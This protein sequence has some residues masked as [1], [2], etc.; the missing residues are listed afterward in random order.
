M[1]KKEKAIY[2]PGELDRLRGKL[3][4]TDAGEAKR[5]AEMLGG[6]VGVERQAAPAAP[7]RRRSGA[8]TAGQGS[9]RSNRTGARAS[10]NMQRSSPRGQPMRRVELAGDENEGPAKFAKTEVSPDPTGDLPVLVKV[11]WFERLKMDYLCAQLEFDIKSPAQ[12]IASIFSFFGKTPDQVNP[13]FITTLLNEYYKQVEVLVNATRSLFPRNNLKRSEGLKKRS[14]FFYSILDTIR[15]WDIEQIAAEIAKLQAH[16]QSVKVA[17]CSELLKLIYRPLF[18]LEQMDMETHIKGAFQLLYKILYIENPVEAKAKYQELIRSAFS[19]FADVRRELHY[20]LYP[21][22]MKLLSDSLLP[23][24]FFFLQQRSRFTAFIGAAEADQINPANRNVRP[25]EREDDE[26]AEEEENPDDRAKQAAR[27][28]EQKALDRGLATLEAL[29]PKAGWNRLSEY[30]DL[31][32]YFREVF[33]FK[34]GYELIAPTDP[35]QQIEILMRILEELFFALRY[36]TFSPITKQGDTSSG[37]DDFLRSIANDWRHY[38]DTCF[39]KEYLPRLTEYCRIL[40]NAAESRTSSYARRTLD[41][42]HWIKRLYFLPYYKFESAFPPPFQKR[43]VTA[44]YSEIRRLR[45]SLTAVAAGIE[46]GY[47][48]GG[49]EKMAPC[50]GIDNPWAPYNFEIPNPVSRRLNALLDPKKRNNA[51][52]IFFSLAVTAVL[53]HLVNDE[54]SWA[55]EDRPGPLFRSINGDGVI[56]QFGVDD[57][58]DVEQILRTP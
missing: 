21:L 29:F 7:P 30:P 5:L 39:E 24:E 47:K 17:E 1:E 32:P 4:V 20:R 58:I 28:A 48:R 11:S 41:E 25:E 46:Q 13:Y 6:E 50:E 45:K 35:L 49:A 42:L 55:Y 26:D 51:S 10:R 19:G 22:L 33:D 44:L 31:Y 27:E 53:D 43:D 8:E 57:K 16:S 3:G 34:K 14:P 2:A 9:G 12:V 15:C 38:I 56:P 18:I 52:L 36:V 40:E 37:V 23:Y 54:S